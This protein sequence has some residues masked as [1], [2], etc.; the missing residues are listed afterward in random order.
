MKIC[1]YIGNGGDSR[2]DKTGK[3]EKEKNGWNRGVMFVC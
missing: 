3:S 2:R 1:D